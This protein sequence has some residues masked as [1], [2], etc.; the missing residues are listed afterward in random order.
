M[1]LTTLFPQSSPQGLPDGSQNMIFIY[2]HFYV[3]YL[4]MYFYLLTNIILTDVRDYLM[5]VISNQKLQRM[6]NKV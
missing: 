4:F 6:K 3:S 1:I 2:Q 5:N